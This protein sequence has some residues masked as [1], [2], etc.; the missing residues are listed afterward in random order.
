MT[1]TMDP[2]GDEI[3]A[4]EKATTWTG[5]RVLEIGCG[6]G[7][8]TLRLASLGPGEI[9][10]LDPDSDRIKAAQESLPG[11]QRGCIKYHVARAGNLEYPPGHV[12]IAVFSWVL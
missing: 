9:Q 1:L 3:R 12:D 11:D 2:A 6:E 8:L 4:L 10:A 7:R 5:K